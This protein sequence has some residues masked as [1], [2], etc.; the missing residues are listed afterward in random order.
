MIIGLSG[1]KGSGKST[2]AKILCDKHGFIELAFADPLKRGI[3]HMLGLTESQLYGHQSEKESKDSFWHVSPR[4]IMQVIG[5]NLM[6]N[7]LPKHL[8]ELHTIWIRMMEK[9]IQQKEHSRIVISD[10]RFLDEA[11]MIRNHNGLILRICRKEVIAEDLHE[12][13]KLAFETD[14][15]IMNSGSL[16]DLDEAVSKFI[17]FIEYK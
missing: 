5:T 12:S 14:Y 7:E 8:P 4:V 11:C 3:Q 9:T 10:C 1:L 13:E 15:T 16:T 2:V 6:R 17:D